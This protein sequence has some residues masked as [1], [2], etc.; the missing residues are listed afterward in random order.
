VNSIIFKLMC[1]CEIVW[2]KKLVVIWDVSSTTAK[3]SFYREDGQS[4]F[5]AVPIQRA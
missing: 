1:C 2:L 5:D 3:R 4:I